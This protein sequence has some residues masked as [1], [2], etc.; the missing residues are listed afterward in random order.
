MIYL[1]IIL[2]G[3]LQGLTEFLPVSSSG[4][5][6]LLGSLFDVSDNFE[7]YVFLN[8][9]TLGA[10]LW[11]SRQSLG[12][13]CQKIGQKNFRLLLIWVLGV[14]P[15][16]L[17]GFFLLDFFRQ[18]EDNL[19][20]VAIMLAFVGFLMLFKPAGRD[21]PVV[22]LEQ[23]SPQKALLIGLAQAVALLP[24]TSRSGAT[25]LSGLW[26]NLK[27][28]LAVAFSFLIGLPLIFGAVLRVVVS[29]EGISYVN[30]NFWLLVIG[31][32]VSFVVGLVAIDW[33]L[34]ILRK[35]S[36]KL[37]GWYRL[38]LASLITVLLLVNVL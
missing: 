21:Q 22:E 17:I 36:L 7:I 26:L 28:E 20:L 38:A 1:T 33:L 12:K 24:G 23:I 9:G 13:I 3:A 25:I 16:G 30:D 15:A 18:L 14:L 37:F 5:L 31:N 2:L 35:F 27:Q 19:I 6:L 34:R 4:H 8:L 29:L 11:Y 32:L 10:L